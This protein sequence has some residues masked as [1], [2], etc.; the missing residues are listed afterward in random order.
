MQFNFLFSLFLLFINVYPQTDLKAQYCALK[1]NTTGQIIVGIN[2]APQIR[3]STEI[4]LKS[5]S[6]TLNGA[7]ISLSFIEDQGSLFIE[8]T[9][10]DINTNIHKD[11]TD[12]T[13][14]YIDS[15]NQYI[16]AKEITD[17]STG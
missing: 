3:T 2:Q 16:L 11:N 13:L 10:S 15:L 1:T 4:I 5:Q 12:N 17:P 6:Y 8:E 9:D 7:T 14:I